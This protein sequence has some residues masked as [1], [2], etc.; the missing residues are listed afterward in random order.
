MAGLDDR[1]NVVIQMT[2]AA[3]GYCQHARCK[4]RKMR[5]TTHEESRQTTKQHVGRRTSPQLIVEHLARLADSG[6]RR[7]YFVLHFPRT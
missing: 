1:V 4:W 7:F 2:L 3:A 5:A 6:F